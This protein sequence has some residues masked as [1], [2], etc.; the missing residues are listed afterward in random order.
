MKRSD[1]LSAGVLALFGAVTAILSLQMPLG[2]LRAA[3]SGL[4]PLCL[5]VLLMILSA[6]SLVR[7]F[8]SQEQDVTTGPSVSEETGSWGPVAAFVAVVALATLLL[9]TLGYPVV[10]FLVMLGLLR[11]LGS[12]RWLFN[13]TISLLTAVAAHTVFV[14]LLKIPLPK[15]IAGI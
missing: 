15:G 13:V 12:R 9:T 8:W 3:G 1:V 4:F 2:T 7:A 5:G 14:Y 6:V 11:V 10:S